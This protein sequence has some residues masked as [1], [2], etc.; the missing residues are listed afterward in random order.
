MSTHMST[1]NFDISIHM[2]LKRLGIVNVHLLAAPVYK[3]HN[4]AVVFDTATK[5]L[6]VLCLLWKDSIINLLTDSEMK[7]TSRI[8][9]VVTRFQ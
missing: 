1:L 8:S 9:D 3:R 2:H 4:A 5:A 6:D 7:I